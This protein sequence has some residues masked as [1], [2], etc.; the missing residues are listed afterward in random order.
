MQ[1][2]IFWAALF[3]LVDQWGWGRGL[4]DTAF[5]VAQGVATVVNFIAQ[6]TVIFVE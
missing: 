5:V 6:R 2:A 1:N 3:L 4:S